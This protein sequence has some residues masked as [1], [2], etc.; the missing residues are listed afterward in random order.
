MMK[1][2]VF[3][4]VVMASL[5]SFANPNDRTAFRRGYENYTNPQVRFA[6]PPNRMH[7]YDRVERTSNVTEEMFNQ[8]TDDAI[9]FFEPVAAAKGVKLIA[10]KDWKDSTVNAS[11]YQS[12]NTWYINM[13]GG[14]AR[15]PEVTPDGYAMVVCHELGH[16]FGGYTFSGGFG[17]WASNEGQSDYFATH[18]CAKIIWGRDFRGNE[19]WRRIRNIPPVVQ[20]KCSMAWPNNVNAQGWCVRTSAAGLSL[21][22]LLNALGG[23]RKPVAFE[24]PDTSVVSR[25]NHAH[26]AAQCRLDTY[27]AG[28][29]CNK[30][31]DINKIPGKGHARGQSSAEAEMEAMQYSCFAKEGHPIGTRPTCWFKPL[32]N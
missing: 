26:P 27:F 15:R 25:T 22:N 28:A 5:V 11:A 9:K 10:N 14:L 13:Y 29:L 4:A 32:V 30:A 23:G 2:I 12:G 31:W 19:S 17:G 3:F 7:I 24:T 18:A 8:I 16:H 21:A 20:E 6:L 1:T